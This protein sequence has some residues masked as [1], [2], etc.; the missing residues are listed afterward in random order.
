MIGKG[1]L[2]EIAGAA[3]S[4]ADVLR[5]AQERVA[6]R[7][8]RRLARERQHAGEFDQ[9]VAVVAGVAGRVPDRISIVPAPSTRTSPVSRAF[10]WNPVPA[11]D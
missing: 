2:Q 5:E 7:E 8:L 6:Q 9:A 3:A 11:G 4:D 10:T 1:K